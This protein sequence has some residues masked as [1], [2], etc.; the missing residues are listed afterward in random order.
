MLFTNLSSV[1][2]LQVCSE[3]RTRSPLIEELCKRLETTMDV[4]M[5]HGIVDK[6]GYINDLKAPL[7]ECPVCLAKLT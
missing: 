6:H 2:L 3:K 7:T 1:E 5:E 4:C